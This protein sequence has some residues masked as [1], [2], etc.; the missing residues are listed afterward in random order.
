MIARRKTIKRTVGR[1]PKSRPADAGTH[2]AILGA[3]RRVFA[4]R[5]VDGTSVREV[6]DAAGVNNAMIYY[7]FRDKTGL[8][9]AVLS[10]SFT[11]LDRIW[12]HPIFQ[13]NAT[14]RQK[15]EKYIE[16]FIRFEHSN[17]DLRRI[18]SIEFATCGRNC[19]WLAN[20]FFSHGFEKL[21]TV[22]IKGMRSG[23]LKKHDPAVALSCL[24][25]MIVHS[26]IMQPVA[27]LI[28]GKKLD[29]SIKRFG[30]F[31][32]DL[33]FDGLG[34]Q[35]GTKTKKNKIGLA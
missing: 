33:F 35:P 20:T 19:T 30:K 26:F 1:P 5:G 17:E 13:G 10:D 11:T 7:H 12:E 22:L 24:I 28:S 31:A 16:E 21:S 34:L 8:Y 18:L 23:E 9:R 29:L 4:R 14:V 6:A 25:G 27:E 15:I 3:A 2:A 32:A